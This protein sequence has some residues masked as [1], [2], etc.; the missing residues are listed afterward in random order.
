LK[1]HAL[2]ERNCDPLAKFALR[3]GEYILMTCHRAENTNDFA[4]LSEIVSAVNSVADSN[5]VLY[6]MHPRTKRFLDDYGLAFSD[7]V[8]IVEPVGYLEMLLLEKGASLILTDS[9]GVQKEAFFYNV[10][11]VT[12]RDETEW[13][14][15]IELGWNVLVGASKDAIEA[16]VA[17]FATNPPATAELKPYGDGDAAGKIL[18]K[19]IVSK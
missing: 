15:T 11:C 6:P 16:A 17:N 9:G 19:I 7:K 2:A 12:M 1:F 5:T 13:V 3:N 4:R 14:E 10:P 8:R 18:E